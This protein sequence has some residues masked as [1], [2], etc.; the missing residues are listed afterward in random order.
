[1]FWVVKGN[2]GAHYLGYWASVFCFLKKI[3]LLCVCVHVCVLSAAQSL[4]VDNGS[5]LSVMIIK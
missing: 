2:K 4:A 1:M 3:Y 5:I